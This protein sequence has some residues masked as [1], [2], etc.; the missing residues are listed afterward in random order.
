MSIDY[1]LVVI[2][3]GPGGYVAAIRAAQLGMKTALIESDALGGVCLNRGCIPTKALLHCA[4]VGRTVAQASQFGWDVPA[5][6]LNLAGVVRHANSTAHRLSGGVSYLMRKHD[7]EVINGWGKLHE[8]GVVQITQAESSRLVSAKHSVI[9]TGAQARQ[10]DSLPFNG[11]SIWTSNDALSPTSVP[12]RL[13]VVGSGAIGIEF[14]SIYNTLGSAVT[15]V[16]VKSGILPA[17][18]TDIAN[19]ARDSL[20]KQGIEIITDAEFSVEHIDDDGVSVNV[21]SGNAKAIHR[22]FDKVLVA[23]GVTGNIDDI[24]LERMGVATTAGHIQTDEWMATNVAGIYAIGDVTGAPW[25]AHKA[26]HEA[27]LCVERIAGLASAHP[28]DKLKVPGCTYSHPQIASIGLTEAA[29][30]ASGKS[31]AVG[32]FSFSANGKALAAGESEG[33]VKSVFD[34]TT[35]EILGVHMVGEGVTEIINSVSV[36]MALECT[37]EFLMRTVFAHPSLSEMLH[38][39]TLDAFNRAIHQ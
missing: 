19:F 13:F 21:K 2:G 18:D 23:V 32:R 38:E 37:E 22:E 31:I 15:V 36:A 27:I 29:A 33:L 3:S 1:D 30:R 39:S 25:L 7:V 26:S 16:E 28:L 14:A 9:A 35:G 5:H 12:K 4:E 6:S 20:E 17:E 34:E 8:P 10:L 11:T 24:G